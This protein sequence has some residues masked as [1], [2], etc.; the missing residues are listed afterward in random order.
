[1]SRVQQPMSGRSGGALAV[2]ALLSPLLWVA[3]TEV[4]RRLAAAATLALV[5]AALV[6]AL[7]DHPDV[8]GGGAEAVDPRPAVTRTG[9]PADAALRSPELAAAAWYA[10][11]LGIPRTQV[12]ALQR[13]RIDNA[14]TRV[15]VIADLGNGRLPTAVVTVHRGR[16]GWKA[17]P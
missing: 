12:R 6:V 8:P 7:Y 2:R 15:L 3:R 9:T 16:T 11:R 1:M 17:V 14:E 4:G 13:Q 10:H 5:T